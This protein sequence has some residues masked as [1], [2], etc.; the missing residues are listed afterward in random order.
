MNILEGTLTKHGVRHGDS[1]LP[2]PEALRQRAAGIEKV[3]YG[4]RPEHLLL[5]DSGLP[6]YVDVVEPTGSDTMVFGKLG[7][8]PIVVN[9]R[10]RV[11]VEVGQT[12]FIQPVLE[13]VHLFD[14]ATTRRI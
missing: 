14:E 10:D 5:A 2:V 3:R 12:I 11:F 9:I 1:L 7:D 4:V 6:V 13:K 8:T